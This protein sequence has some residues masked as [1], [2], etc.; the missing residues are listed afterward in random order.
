MFLFKNQSCERSCK[1]CT[2][3]LVTLGVDLKLL[4]PPMLILFK[5]VILNHVLVKD[6]QQTSKICNYWEEL[7]AVCPCVSFC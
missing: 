3:P 4:D 5:Q 2:V 7:K 6:D 1:G